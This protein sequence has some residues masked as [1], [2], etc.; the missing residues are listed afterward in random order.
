[1]YEQ[2]ATERLISD[3]LSRSQHHAWGYW[4]CLVASN[5]ECA[6]AHRSTSSQITIDVITAMKRKNLEVTLSSGNFGGGSS[7]VL[8]PQAG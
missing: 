4:E 1:M 3:I 2:V 5:Q 6:I 7:E 8:Y